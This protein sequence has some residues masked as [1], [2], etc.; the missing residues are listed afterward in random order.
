MNITSKLCSLGMTAVVLSFTALGSW[1]ADTE[2]TV[3][4]VGSGANAAKIAVASNF[5]AAA[6]NLVTAFQQTTNGAN[7]AI[8]ICHNS[9]T[10][11]VGE[12]NNGTGL[13]SS[14]FPTDPGFPRYNMFFAANVSAASGLQTTT[15]NTAFTYAYG[16]PVF[17]G[18]RSTIGTADNLIYDQTGYGA[19]I[20]DTCSNAG[21][22]QYEINTNNA[23][24]VALAGTGAPYG[25]K[26]HSIINAIT[27]DEGGNATTLPTT[28][29]S[30]GYS[31]LF[32][33]IDLTYDA[34][35][36]GTGGIK[37]GFVGKSQICS[38]ISSGIPAN[39]VSYVEFTG[40]DCRLQQAAILL[41][42]LSG[43]NNTT[44]SA[45]NSYIQGRISGGTWNT[46][47]TSECYGTL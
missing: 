20:T 42:T 46:F 17:F 15:G 30:W 9:T 18:L 27:S 29:P 26:S 45:L 7:T 6:Q 43:T 3:K 1:A 19:T 4:T 41:K 33:N 21:L 22:A 5:Y 10:H 36:A 11:L 32:D 38:R 12:I 14:V 34:I 37:S 13:P 23:Q 16:I 40:T 28:I 47:L 2:C 39:Q 31:T 24:Y 44:A 35:I 8:T 25:V